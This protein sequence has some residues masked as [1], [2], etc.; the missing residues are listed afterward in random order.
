MK[1]TQSCLTLCDPIYLYRA[2]LLCPW[3]SPGQNTG[4]SSYSLLRGN[5]PNSGIEPRSPTSQADSLPSEPPGNP[6]NIICSC[7]CLA[8]ADLSSCNRDLVV[9]KAKKICYLAFYRKSLL[10]S[11]SKA[12]RD[13]FRA[14]PPQSS[15]APS[16]VFPSLPPASEQD[17]APGLWNPAYRS[18]LSV[19]SGNLVINAAAFSLSLLFLASHSMLQKYQMA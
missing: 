8:Y 3:N 5:F 6:L 10:T 16:P 13:R 11:V 15:A 4:V 9:N 12:R 14:V 18:S 2:K 1:V 7:F 19:S 17:V